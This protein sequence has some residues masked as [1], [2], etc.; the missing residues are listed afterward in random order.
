[1]TRILVS[2]LSLIFFWD[3]P[4]LEVAKGQTWYIRYTH[5]ETGRQ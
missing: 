3:S 1:M 4:G 2:I 5:E